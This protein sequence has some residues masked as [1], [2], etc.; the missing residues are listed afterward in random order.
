MTA[1]GYQ[2]GVTPANMQDLADLGLSDPLWAPL[3]DF[4]PWSDLKMRGDGE[5]VGRGLASVTWRFNELSIEQ[6]GALLYYCSTGGALV[7]SKTVYIRTRV[8]SPNMTDRVFQ[9]YQAR[10]LC[11]IEP[12]DLR[13]E[14][15]RKYLNLELRFVQAS[16]I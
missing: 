4:T 3:S 14:D 6:L 1:T 5:I 13:Y 9:N 11:P 16:A 8:P 10:M 2:I 15:N 12:E 7:A